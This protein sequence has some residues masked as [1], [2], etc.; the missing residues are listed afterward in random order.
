MRAAF[1]AISEQFQYAR[2]ETRQLLFYL[3]VTKNGN[4]NKSAAS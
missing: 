1:I 4:E 3:K 2:A